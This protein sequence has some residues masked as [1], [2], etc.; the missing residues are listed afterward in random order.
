MAQ[1]SK[2]RGLVAGILSPL[3]A[4]V[5]YAL[6]YSILTR[7]SA[8]LEKDWLFRLSLSTLAMTLPFLV[9]LVFAIKDRDSSGDVSLD[10]AAWRGITASNPYPTLPRDFG[11]QYL[12]LRF[13][14]LYNPD[15]A[16][17]SAPN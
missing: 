17:I 6:V 1:P 14:F 12:A 11:G 15:H 7:A 3:A 5:L 13:R 8:D 16:T 2:Y 9:A 10:L 4:L